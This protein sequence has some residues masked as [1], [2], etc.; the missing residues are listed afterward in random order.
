M[1]SGTL[2]SAVGYA[3]LTLTA[4]GVIAFAMK[5]KVTADKNKTFVTIKKKSLKYVKFEF[6]FF[7]YTIRL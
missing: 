5:K 4:A 7:I 1:E 6:C 3:A 2:T